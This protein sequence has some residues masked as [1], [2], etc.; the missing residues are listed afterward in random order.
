[1]RALQEVNLHNPFL[2]NSPFFVPQHFYSQERNNNVSKQI[3]SRESSPN[4]P[5]ISGK[6]ASPN[7]SFY[8]SRYQI[9]QVESLVK[10]KQNNN[11][12]HTIKKYSIAKKQNPFF[13]KNLLPSSPLADS[14][15]NNQPKYHQILEPSG[16]LLES[17]EDK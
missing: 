17:K 10:E 3:Y 6:I 9:S 2:K 11:Q 14:F 16:K 4:N 1:M 5:S 12:H 7:S 8:N 13:R 15:A